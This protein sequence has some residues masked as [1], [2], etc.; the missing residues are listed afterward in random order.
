MAEGL[1][2]NDNIEKISLNYCNIDKEGSKYIQSVLAN[3][4]SKLRTLKLQGN[5]LGNEGFYEVLRG[6]VSCG[7]HLE[8][9]NLADTG[10]NILGYKIDEIQVSENNLE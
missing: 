5:P 8:K 7:H 10:L 1:R 3:L 9:L 4:N 2:S 6:V